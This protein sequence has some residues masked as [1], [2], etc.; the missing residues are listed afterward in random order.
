MLGISF[1]VGKELLAVIACGPVDI[2]PIVLQVGTDSVDIY[3]VIVL[4]LQL[5]RTIHVHVIGEG[6]SREVATTEG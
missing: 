3:T 4:V 6:E 5:T 1:V 2:A